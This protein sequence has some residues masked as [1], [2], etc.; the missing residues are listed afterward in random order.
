MQKDMMK[1]NYDNENDV[2]YIGLGDG[3][4]SYGDDSEAGVIY[5][6]DIDTDKLTGLTFIDFIKNY[7]NHR[8]PTLGGLPLSYDDIYRRLNVEEICK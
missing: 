8:L 6:R 7:L 1:L 4:N 5:L 3:K 2:L